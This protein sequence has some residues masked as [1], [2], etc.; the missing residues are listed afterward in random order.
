[1]A[2]PKRKL[3]TYQGYFKLVLTPL[4]TFNDGPARGHQVVFFEVRRKAD[5]WDGK[6]QSW[7]KLMCPCDLEW[8]WTMWNGRRQLVHTNS[9]K[10]RCPAKE[11]TRETVRNELR[12]EHG[13]RWRAMPLADA[14]YDIY[15]MHANG[16]Y[17]GEHNIGMLY[18][19][20]L[21][22]LLGTTPAT[23]SFD[24]QKE[25]SSSVEIVQFE[26]PSAEILEAV[27]TLRGRKLLDL[28]GMI[29]V[30]YQESFRFPDTLHNFFATIIETPLG[31]PNGDKGDGILWRLYAEIA[32]RTG[33][34]SGEEVFGEANIPV[35]TQV[36]LDELR[37]RW[38]VLLD[39][40][41]LDEESDAFKRADAFHAITTERWIAWLTEIRDHLRE[42]AGVP[43]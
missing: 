30:P 13:A 28:S 7:Q 10:D 37:E 33:W 39:P 12:A 16:A 1:M 4:R 42:H 8:K 35:V 36:F 43:D 29:L 3:R 34:Q 32:E 18:V 11:H 9:D 31:W 2:L 26:Y 41:L 19:Q 5:L 6:D 24:A 21:E 15:Q 38:L 20:D 17:L 14:A 23:I 25:G 22:R 27:D 40:I